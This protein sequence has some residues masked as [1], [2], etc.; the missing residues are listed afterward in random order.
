MSSFVR[1]KEERAAGTIEQSLCHHL[2]QQLTSYYRTV[3]ILETQ[4]TM[5][6]C[7]IE[8]FESG[9]PHVGLTLRRLEVWISEWGLRMRLMSIFVEN[10]KSKF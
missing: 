1:S 4:L 7:D 8:G 6:D 9:S 2:Q 3:A 10:A 5:N